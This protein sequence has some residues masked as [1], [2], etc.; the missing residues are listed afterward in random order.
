M[1]CIGSQEQSEPHCGVQEVAG[2]VQY[3]QEQKG[4]HCSVKECSLQEQIGPR[5][6]V[7]EIAEV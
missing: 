1:V 4:P 6:K 7:Q 2:S 3:M 5:C